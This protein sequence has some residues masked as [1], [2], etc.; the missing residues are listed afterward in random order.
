MNEFWILFVLEV[1]SGDE[2]KSDHY[3]IMSAMNI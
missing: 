2:S 3:Q 1:M